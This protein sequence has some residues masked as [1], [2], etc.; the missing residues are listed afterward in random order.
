MAFGRQENERNRD[1][2]G[3]S[4]TKLQETFF[5]FLM[6]LFF[7][8]LFNLNK[9]FLNLYAGGQILLTRPFFFFFFLVKLRRAL[10]AEKNGGSWIIKV[11]DS[12]FN[13]ETAFV[14]VSVALTLLS[15]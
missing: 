8:F 7:S 1:F 15:R 11:R 14:F 3:K 6:S 9:Y 10:K 12:A 4:W 2:L 5:F 13:G